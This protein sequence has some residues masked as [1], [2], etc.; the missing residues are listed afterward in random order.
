[1]TFERL[2]MAF[3]DRF[4]SQRSYD[5]IVAP[6][7]ADLQYEEDAGRRS[8]LSNRA[9]IVRALA[10]GARYEMARSSGGFL[11]LTL[12]SLSYYAFPVFVSVRIFK[13]WSDFFL[14]AAIVFVISL[15]PVMVCF[16]PSR[17]PIR[18]G[19]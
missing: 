10:G 13:T 4:L 11:K 9:A 5:L 19:D 3:C 1:M 17:H 6:A 2:I 8:W 14:A 7:L 12:L 18:H 15:V 16:W